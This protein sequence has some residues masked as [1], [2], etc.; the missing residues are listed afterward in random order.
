MGAT[1]GGWMQIVQT[2]AT[3][4]QSGFGATLVM[5]AVAIAGARAALHGHWGHFWS[6]IGGGAV[7]IS[8]AWVV[9]T[10]LGGNAVVGGG[11]G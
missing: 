4:I 11:G 7:V 1:S 6:A 8:A 3:F 9:T 10:F 5:I 2:I